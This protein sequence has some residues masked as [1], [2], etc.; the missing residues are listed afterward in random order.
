MRKKERWKSIIAIV[1]SCSMILPS[2][3]VSAA[4]VPETEMVTE[5]LQST[6][7]ENQEIETELLTESETYQVETQSQTETENPLDNRT[8][9]IEKSEAPYKLAAEQVGKTYVSEQTGREQVNFNREWKF[10]RN[11]IPG[12]ESVDYDDSQW[13]DI[14]IPHNFSIPYE[15]QASFYVGYGWYRKE[16]E[17]SDNMIGKKIELEFEG[18]FQEAEIYVNGQ[19][20]GTHRGGYSGFVFDITDYLNSGKNLIAVRVN[21]IWQPDLAPRAGD[22]QF[23]GGIYRDVYL[24]ITD[25]VHVTWYGTFVTTPD[26]SNPGFDPSAKNIPDNYASEEEILN[27]IEQKQSNVSVSTEIKNDSLSEALVKVKQE[28]VDKDGIVQAVFESAEQNISAGSAAE[29][30]AVSEKIKNIQLW[31]TENPYVYQLYTTV[32]RIPKWCSGR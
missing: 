21:N 16:F 32:Y 26:L 23:T 30:T 11:D 18:V 19:P 9:T 3:A 14:G 22:H 20:A 12:A 10:I 27:N 7:V 4:Q 29:I 13:V 15:M 5:A 6:P 31:D 2:M 1:L 8:S 28:V 25:E 17:V 24:N